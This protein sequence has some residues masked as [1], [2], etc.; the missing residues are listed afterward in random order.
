MQPKF[1]I[2]HEKYNRVSIV[3]YNEELKVFA[4]V[5]LDNKWVIVKEDDIIEYLKKN[6]GATLT[7]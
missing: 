5:N 6:A 7:E 1:E 4:L 2:K 3:S